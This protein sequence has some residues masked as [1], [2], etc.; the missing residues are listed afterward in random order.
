MT[1]WRETKERRG[2]PYLQMA[3]RRPDKFMVRVSFRGAMMGRFAAAWDDPIRRA[4]ILRSLWWISTGFTLFG[5]A[6]IFYRVL[7]AR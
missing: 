4:K 6:V 1:I 3:R 5:F 2:P 7:F